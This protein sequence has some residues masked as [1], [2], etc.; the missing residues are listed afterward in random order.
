MKI[1]TLISALSLLSLL[2]ITA[3]KAEEE[4]APLTDIFVVTIKDSDREA[5]EAALRAHMQF[6]VNQG[7]PNKW[8]VYTQVVGE[9][10]ET[11]ILR[12]C[13]TNWDKIA[14][15]ADWSKNAKTTPHWRKHVG[16]YVV[17]SA[18][19]YSRYDTENSSWDDD[20]QFKYF[21]V[22]S[23]KIAPGK[24]IQAR[25][26]IKQVSDVAKQMQWQDSW[27]WHTRIGGEAQVQ[28][29]FGYQAYEDMMPP[30]KSFYQRLVEQL[31]SDDEARAM[32]ESYGSV[33]SS[34]NYAIYVLR[35]SL[36]S[37]AS[38]SK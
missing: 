1:K 37:P 23:L 21:G 38:R 13:C 22:E 20:K 8:H 18:H 11:Y 5:F 4:V 6:R 7:E 12:S 19:Y 24:G 3:V 29:V 36:S 17:D 10:L 26:A 14:E 28:L 31:G 30:E 15:H 35:K 33:F 2:F 32:I 34:S 16:K 9:E 25:E 27:S